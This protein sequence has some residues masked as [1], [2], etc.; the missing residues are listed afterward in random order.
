VSPYDRTG[1]PVDD[2]PC[3]CDGGWLDR[4][5]DHPVPCPACKPWLT[6]AERRRRVHG[7]DTGHPS[8]EETPS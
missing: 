8:R 3:G 5:A 7:N 6:Q 1:E 2:E 4:E